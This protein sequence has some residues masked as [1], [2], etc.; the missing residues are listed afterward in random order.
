MEKLNLVYMLNP[1]IKK[2]ENIINQALTLPNATLY[3]KNED[4][5]NFKI[6]PNCKL[7]YIQIQEVDLNE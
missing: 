2:A 1:P 5:E 7:I 6:K 4:G 3:I